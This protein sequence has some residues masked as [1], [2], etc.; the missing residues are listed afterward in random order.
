MS[1]TCPLYKAKVCMYVCVNRLCVQLEARVV[2]CEGAREGWRCRGP[3]V[4]L[5]SFRH[6]QVARLFISFFHAH[7]GHIHTFSARFVP[8]LAAC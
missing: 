8:V 3:L 6:L 1:T 4:Q 7:N 5:H 2:T